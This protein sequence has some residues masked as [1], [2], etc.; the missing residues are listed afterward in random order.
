MHLIVASLTMALFS[1]REFQ[2][3]VKHVRV[4][5]QVQCRL[6][7][8]ITLLHDSVVHESVLCKVI[9][10]LRYYTI[11]CGFFSIRCYLVTLLRVYLPLC[12]RYYLI[13]L[14]HG[15]VLQKA[16]TLLPY[17]AITRF[18]ASAFYMLLPYYAV[19]HV[20]LQMCPPFSIRCYKFI[21]FFCFTA[22]SRYYGPL[23][24]FPF[25]FQ[26]LLVLTSCGILL[27]D[28]FGVLY[29]GKGYQPHQPFKDQMPQATHRVQ[30]SQR[31]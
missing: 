16:I 15:Y 9:T 27:L 4:F 17:Y 30:D 10:L 21:F 1:K 6:Y 13:T 29:L 18:S 26:C 19:T 12:L 2:Y 20:S 23:F 31:L 8:V 5:C 7:Y 24:S 28:Y 11:I 22:F 3:A 14:L 25:H